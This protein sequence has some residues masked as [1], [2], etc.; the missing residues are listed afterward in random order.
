MSLT[1]S[2]ILLFPKKEC[3]VFNNYSSYSFDSIKHSLVIQFD[4]SV[5]MYRLK[6]R[7]AL[8]VAV[9]SV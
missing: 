2:E 7:R 4:D 9:C 5:R 6:H 3:V 8:S 1:F